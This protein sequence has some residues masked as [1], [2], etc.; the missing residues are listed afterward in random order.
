MTCRYL[1][2]KHL[3][4]KKTY[5]YQAWSREI[6]EYVNQWV[7]DID[8]AESFTKFR[9]EKWWGDYENDEK[10]YFTTKKIWV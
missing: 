7:E 2:V 10:A 1:I 9:T 8:N 4:G 5:L 3:K 6:D